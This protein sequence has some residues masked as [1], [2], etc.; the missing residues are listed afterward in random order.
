MKKIISTIAFIAIAYATHSDCMEDNHSLLHTAV[1]TSVNRE[2][3]DLTL[4]NHDDKSAFKL[5]QEHRHKSAD[6]MYALLNK[7]AVKAFENAPYDHEEIKKLMHAG[8]SINAKDEEGNTP[9]HKV[10]IHGSDDKIIELLLSNPHINLTLCNKAGQFPLDVAPNDTYRQRIQN[11]LNNQLFTS[12]V[13]AEK[14]WVKRAVLAGASINAQD[15]D[16]NTPLHKA[17]MIGSSD[18]TINYLLEYKQHEDE[19]TEQ[20]L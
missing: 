4:C 20:K 8:A 19:S 12:V 6:T 17:L 15:I 3:A 9:L 16:G 13:S 18:E 5:A 2:K 11:D 14:S 7:R 10:L 1:H